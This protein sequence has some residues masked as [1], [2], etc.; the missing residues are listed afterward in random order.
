MINKM[1]SENEELGY[2]D[3]PEEE[4]GGYEENFPEE[5]EGGYEEGGGSE[6]PF[7]E[8]IPSPRRE[9]RVPSPRQEEKT[10]TPQHA[11]DIAAERRNF[12]A[13]LKK[14]TQN[15]T[16]RTSSPV[17]K[18]S[19]KPKS[20]QV[21]PTQEF[22][23]VQHETEGERLSRLLLERT[24]VEWIE[25]TGLGMPYLLSS[26]ISDIDGYMQHNFPLEMWTRV[27]YT[28]PIT[29]DPTML[30]ILEADYG[31]MIQFLITHPGPFNNALSFIDI[32]Q[33]IKQFTELGTTMRQLS[34]EYLVF[35]FPTVSQLYEEL[36]SYFPE[37]LMNLLS[38]VETF[39]YLFTDHISLFSDYYTEVFPLF[40]PTPAAA[41][42]K[43]R[44]YLAQIP[45]PISWI[46]FRGSMVGKTHAAYS[47]EQYENELYTL[48]PPDSFQRGSPG[49]FIIRP[50][51]TVYY[52]LWNLRIAEPLRRLQLEEEL[53][54][55]Q[56][57]SE[58]QHL[59]GE[60]L[61]SAEESSNIQR[62]LES[63]RRPELASIILR[64]HHLFPKPEMSHIRDLISQYLRQPIPLLL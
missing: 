33:C 52:T 4:E 34:Q 64:G 55:H 17:R 21:Q 23:L 19:P 56:F 28:N 59:T 1:E 45:I 35:E 46:E 49:T 41:S 20:P 29:R 27:Q 18:E 54:S 63:Q 58:L 15:R 42:I 50:F 44:K 25:G 43:L 47:D 12:F 38:V 36:Q 61:N 3:F 57:P 24:G 30:H 53:K 6:K 39:V 60:Y 10:P 8:T 40:R 22:P 13:R 7:E 62:I 14:E 32:K 2:E 16:I 9:K 31:T 11:R 51:Y 5:E 48:L 37:A 26:R